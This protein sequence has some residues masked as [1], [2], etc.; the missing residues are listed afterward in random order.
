MI[1][2]SVLT[3]AKAYV[4]GEIVDC[5][6][7]IENGKIFKI[8][9]E[10]QMP[11]ADEK[12]NLRSL[13][14]LPGLID[15]HVHLRDEGKAYK[16]DFYSGTA[17]AA[18]GGMTTVLDM[19]N[20]DPVTMS[21]ETLKN[22]M[23]IAER[24]VLVNVGFYSEFPND[25]DEIK[26]I[27]S[28]GAMAFKLFMACQIGGLNIDDDEALQDALKKVG[29]LGVPVAVHAEDKAALMV[30]EEEMKKTERRDVGAFLTAHSER[31]ELRAIERLLKISAQVNMR[32][33]FCHM[34]I[35]E[36][37]NAVIEAKKSGRTVTCEVTPNHLLLSNTDF[38]RYGSLIIMMPPLRSKSHIV[39]LWKGIANGWIDVIGSDHAPHALKEKSASS[40][41]DVKVGVP[42]LETTLPL[43]LTMVRKN[44]LSLAHLVRLLSEKPAEIFNLKDR[45]RLEQGRKAD[46]AVID[47]NRKFK[48]DASKF[49]SKAKYSPYDG[50]EVQ[51]RPVKT[52]VNGLL[53]M[54]EQE[55][56]A[57]AGSGEI[58]RRD[59]A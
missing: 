40:I 58:I 5:S 43:M 33:H 51:G 24:K 50:W 23:Q 29:D 2:D 7:A 48:I 4:D 37:L 57:K 10:T 16:E 56:V 9:K 12:I 1:V 44:R 13:L 34:T 30:A 20:N 8:G 31:V 45:G 22:R 21:A 54:D 15:V 59:R 47:F 49:H 41:W 17:A 18:A 14:V 35:E 55:I 38:E 19:P 11:K 6:L 42:G 52:F 53:I 3:N 28:Q 36:G 26:D 27:V 39:A 46:L 25:L 32:L